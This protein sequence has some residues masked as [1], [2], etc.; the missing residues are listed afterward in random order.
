MQNLFKFSDYDIFAYIV[1]GLALMIGVDIVLGWDTV[2]R[3]DGSMT[4]GEGAVRVLIAYVLGLLVS[5]PSSWLIQRIIEHRIVGH[6][7]GF[8]MRANAD[9]LPGWRARGLARWVFGN[10]HRPAPPAV[11]SG[12]STRLRAAPGWTEAN[13]TDVETPPTGWVPDDWLKLSEAVFFTA[14]P[15]ALRDS[16][17]AERME[18]FL[19]LYGFCRNLAFVLLLC[20]IGFLVQW[21]IGTG[22]PLLGHAASGAGAG[23][24]VIIVPS[25]AAAARVAPAPKADT[26]RCAA[27]ALDDKDPAAKTFLPTGQC[28]PMFSHGWLTLGAALFAFLL[29]LR[30]LYFH[31]LYAV[32]VLTAYSREKLPQPP[33]PAAAILA[34]AGTLVAAAQAAAAAAPPPPPAAQQ[35]QQGP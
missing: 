21:I 16:A 14:H 25:D 15:S 8:L 30:F 31:R 5:S 22:A 13:V 19:K 9:V 10:Y 4:L 18:T 2:L 7:F 20:T 34:A 27:F 29:F 35:A 6:P 3:R 11:R 33:P 26:R 24:T 12:A 1:A 28:T 32:E 17:A 23:T